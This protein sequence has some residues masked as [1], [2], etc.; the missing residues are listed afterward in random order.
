MWAPWIGILTLESSH[1]LAFVSDNQ[2]TAISSKVVVYSG[3]QVR[4]EAQL[5][6]HTK[7][8]PRGIVDDDALCVGSCLQRNLL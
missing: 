1:V 6:T 3:E 8:H 7:A 2:A 5:K 4:H